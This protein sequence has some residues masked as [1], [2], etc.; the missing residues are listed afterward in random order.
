[1]APFRKTIAGIRP[2][3]PLAGPKKAIRVTGIRGPRQECFALISRIRNSETG[4][5]VVV[6]GGLCTYGTQAAGEF[7]TD[8]QL[9]QAIARC[10]YDVQLAAKRAMPQ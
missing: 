2:G 9:M 10:L 8:P 7:L 5:V 6:V 3:D 1:M 4:H